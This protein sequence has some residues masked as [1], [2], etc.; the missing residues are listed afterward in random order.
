MADFTIKDLDA[1]LSMR[2]GGLQAISTA[3]ENRQ[4]AQVKSIEALNEVISG[5]HDIHSLNYAGSVIDVVS[6]SLAGNP[7]AQIKLIEVE[8]EHNDLSSDLHNYEHYLGKA[9]EKVNAIKEY[10]DTDWQKLSVE[11]IQDDLLMINNF[12]DS[13][14]EEP[15]NR[16]TEDVQ[17]KPSTFKGNSFVGNTYSG[18]MRDIEVINR[19]QDYQKN[20]TAAAYALEENG[21]IDS[22]ELFAVISGN[23][24]ALVERKKERMDEASK[25]MDSL[26]TSINTIESFKKRIISKIAGENMDDK[27]YNKIVI[28]EMTT[29]IL[30]AQSHVDAMK[31]IESGED[32]DPLSAEAWAAKN[33]VDWQGMSPNQIISIFS[34][35]QDVLRILHDKEHMKYYKWGA[36]EYVS[37]TNVEKRSQE[38]LMMEAQKVYPDKTIKEIRELLGLSVPK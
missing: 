37:G 20:L 29:D 5:V 6:P 3:Q 15:L 33:K 17:G 38:N 28:Q 25:S 32:F 14:A 34:G 24:K 7:E 21:F 12:L 1:L 36:S 27:D 30:L 8:N 22:H 19:V 4:K 23:K 11:N 18:G 13:A 10:T 2:R 9:A 31:K 26:R 16:K 35:E